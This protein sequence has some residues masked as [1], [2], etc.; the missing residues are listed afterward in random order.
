MDLPRSSPLL[1]ATGYALSRKATLAVFLPDPDV[2]IDI[3]HL[4]RALRPI[5]LGKKNWLFAW[6]EVGARQ[7]G[8]VRSL[9]VTCRLHGINPWTYLV[10]VLQRIS[11]HPASQIEQLTPRR[12][13]QHFA[14]D[15]LL[16][17]IQWIDH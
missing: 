5:P 16:S 3:N 6:T 17:D 4:E 11:G 10:D 14:D 7:I 2:P 8:V 13:K 9:L 12:W 1:T 15:P